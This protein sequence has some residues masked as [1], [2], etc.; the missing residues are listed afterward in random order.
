MEALALK[1]H[2]LDISLLMLETGE[3]VLNQQEIKAR[4]R[5]CRGLPSGSQL[6]QSL[7]LCFLVLSMLWELVEDVTYKNAK[8]QKCCF[9]FTKQ[10]LWPINLAYLLSLPLIPLTFSFIGSKSLLH[11]CYYISGTRDLG[12]SY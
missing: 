11:I 8:E 10:E 3:T 12:K 1:D 4:G 5:V 6:F 9:I 7:A 2:L